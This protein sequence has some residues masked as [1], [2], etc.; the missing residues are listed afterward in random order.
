M[1]LPPSSL[2]FE[3]DEEGVAFK[4]RLLCVE[5]RLGPMGKSGFIP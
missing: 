3:Q 1:L 2:L 5:G 4:R